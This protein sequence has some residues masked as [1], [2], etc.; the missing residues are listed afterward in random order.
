M[1]RDEIRIYVLDYL[2]GR[3]TC[4]KWVE[5]VTDYLEGSLSLWPRIRFHLHLGL[6][7]GCR[8]YL[9]QVRTTIKTTQQ[10]PRE[11]T[12]PH[13]REELIRRF[14]SMSSS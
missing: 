7:N 8:H 13:V 9:Q 10:L 14:R 6:C 5:M 12:P 1:T 2:A 4:K 3:L 11:P